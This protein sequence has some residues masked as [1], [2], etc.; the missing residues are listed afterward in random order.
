MLDCERVR[1]GLGEDQERHAGPAVHECG[2][3]V[4]GGADLDA[5]DVAQPR[6][7]A[8]VV[9]LQHD[10]GELFRRR[11]PAERLHVELIGLL[12]GDRRLVQHARRDLDVLRAQRG[13]HLARVQ[14]MRGDLVR[15]EPDSHGVFAAAE[16]LHV[17]DAG[18]SRQHVLHMQRRIVRDVERVARA[19]GRIEMHRE[20]DVGRRFPHLH[21]EP[22]HVLGQAGQRVLH[23]VLRQ[24]LRDVEIGAD[25]E[26]HGDGELAVAG[27]LAVD[28]DHVLDAVDLLL[29]RRRDRARNGLGGSAGI[30]A[31]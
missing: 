1:A 6:H 17:A 30:G 15:I 4:I 31:W 20:Q 19:V 14:I 28:I 5:A 27:R 23:A 22:L 9:R 24:H 7:A 3:A 21:A 13:E 29:E 10:G 2:R 16:D 8:L 18:Q 26:G 25:P 11:K 12:R